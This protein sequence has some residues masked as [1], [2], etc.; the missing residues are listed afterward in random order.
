LLYDSL[1][2]ATDTGV[3]YRNKN[4]SEWKRISCALPNIL[5]SDLEINNRPQKI[6]I[7]T[8]GGVWETSLAS[9]S[10]QGCTSESYLL[11]APLSHNFFDN[12]L[13]KQF[14]RN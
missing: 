12:C 4:L 10:S 11:V 14:A 1:F 13:D 8:R 2:V 3:Y 5:V 6:R 7:A 9:I